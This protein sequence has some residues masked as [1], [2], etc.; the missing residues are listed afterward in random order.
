MQLYLDT[1]K[2]MQVIVRLGESVLE[3]NYDK[4]QE[5]NIL[6]A[7]DEALKNNNLS[8]KDLEAIEVNPGPGSFTGTRVGVAIA[9]SLAFALGIPINNQNPPIKVIYSEDPHITTAKNKS[10]Y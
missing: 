2:P 5:Q 8:L 1:T 3:K 4:P 9:N 6:S 7:I 10:S